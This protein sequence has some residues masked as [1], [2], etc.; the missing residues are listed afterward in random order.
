MTRWLIYIAIL[1]SCSA[2][3]RLQ[4]RVEGVRVRCG[5][6]V[7][8]VV[9]CRGELE[10]FFAKSPDSRI[11]GVD[12][13]YGTG[14]TELLVWTT[15]EP[16]WPRASDLR[17][18]EVPCASSA[19]GPD[20]LSAIDS[21]WVG[22]ARDQHAFIVPLFADGSR[23]QG[24]WSFLDVQTHDAGLP[25]PKV[26]EVPCRMNK[27]D[28]VLFEADTNAMMQ[29]ATVKETGTSAS[30]CTFALLLYLRDH[31]DQRIRSIVA[32]D[33]KEGTLALLLLTGT[34]IDGSPRARDL[35]IGQMPC[36]PHSDC[37]SSVIQFRE[38]PE[39]ASAV[40]TVPLALVY[41]SGPEVVNVLVASMS[42]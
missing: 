18:R 23:G 30:R 31:P 1:S 24:S 5:T 37:A 34:A 15:R 41:E 39:H 32:E 35:V 17:V 12:E 25:A 22:P 33:T 6:A 14:G 4:G 8:D 20:C 7:G 40:F 26:V 16:G 36:L 10:A 29:I 42:K 3:V 9:T 19:E 13:I 38:L 21:L 28:P 11:A 2:K 27:G